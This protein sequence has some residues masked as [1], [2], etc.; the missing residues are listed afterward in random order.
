M[1]T[2]EIH[3]SRLRAKLGPELRLETVR[4]L[5]YRLRAPEGLREDAVPAAAAGSERF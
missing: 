3:V 4:R 1:A 2:V 5:G